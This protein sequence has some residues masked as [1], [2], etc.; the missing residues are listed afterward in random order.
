[1][2]PGGVGAGDTF[3]LA[4]GDTLARAGV[5]D[6]GAC[7]AGLVLAPV[8]AGVAWGVTGGG[9]TPAVLL[10]PLESAA[11][12]A[13]M[14]G[15]SMGMPWPANDGVG[16]GPIAAPTATPMASMPAVNAALTLNEGRRGCRMGVSG[17]VVIGLA[18]RTGAVS[19]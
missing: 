16:A 18:R 17:G 3:V 11:V 12:S 5:F 1:M 10:W 19:S 15:S 9:C 4:V 2:G 14:D 7:T 6:L 8:L 13:A